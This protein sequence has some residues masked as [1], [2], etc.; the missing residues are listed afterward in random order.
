MQNASISKCPLKS[1]TI[2]KHYGIIN[3]LK[4]SE[5]GIPHEIEFEGER[6]NDS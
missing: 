3:G 5:N 1:K 2:P 6:F 4:S